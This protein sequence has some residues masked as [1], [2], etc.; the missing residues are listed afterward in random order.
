MGD[1][2]IDIEVL[3]IYDQIV[4]VAMRNGTL[5]CWIFSAI[6]ASPHIKYRA[7]LWSYLS[8]LGA[9]INVP[10]SLMGSESSP[11]FFRKGER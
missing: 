3:G 2:I 1:N 10:W 7:L 5:V 6:Y 9:N 11:F 8:Q 4:T